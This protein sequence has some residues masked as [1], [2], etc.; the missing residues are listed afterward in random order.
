MM[1]LTMLSG[2]LQRCAGQNQGSKVRSV[3]QNVD[4]EALTLMSR[5]EESPFVWP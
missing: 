2:S 5:E 4:H 1:T 3:H